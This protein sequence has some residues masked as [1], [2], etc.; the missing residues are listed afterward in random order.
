MQLGQAEVCTTTN[1]AKS[2][3]SLSHGHNV[4]H[5][6]TTHPNHPHTTQATHI[7]H[8]SH[9]IVHG[10]HITTHGHVANHHSH[11]HSH[12][13]LVGAVPH[14]TNSLLETF[15]TEALCQVQC[16]DCQKVSKIIY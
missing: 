5:V 11:G 13:V 9:T 16:I 15:K 12:G 8:V 3:S 1:N 10:N 4:T 2:Q 6:H 7:S 14:Y